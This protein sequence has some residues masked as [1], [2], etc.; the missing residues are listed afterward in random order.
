M[1]TLASQT[2]STYELAVASPGTRWLVLA[3]NP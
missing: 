3:F 1:E 2:A